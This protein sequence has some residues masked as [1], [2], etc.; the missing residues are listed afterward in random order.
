MGLSQEFLR[1]LREEAPEEE[2]ETKV[3]KGPKP[4]PV[5]LMIR[6]YGPD[7]LYMTSVPRPMADDMVAK[8]LATWVNEDAIKLVFATYDMLKGPGLTPMQ[9]A[10]RKAQEERRRR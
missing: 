10:R 5:Y 9:K 3:P 4:N 7:T 6:V 1:S 2:P 8:E